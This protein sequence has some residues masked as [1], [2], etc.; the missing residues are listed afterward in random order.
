MFINDRFMTITRVPLFC[1]IDCIRKKPGEPCRPSETVLCTRRPRGRCGVHG[2]GTRVVGNGDNVRGVCVHRGM[3]PGPLLH[4]CS[5]HWTTT[6]AS[7]GPLLQPPLDHYR[8]WST[9]VSGPQPS[10]VRHRL[11]SDT[12]SGPT[13]ILVR[14]RS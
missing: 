7:T 1:L 3:G 13:P 9:T 6:A 10:L 8:L 14:H 12:D 2:G 11:W 5:L 4:H